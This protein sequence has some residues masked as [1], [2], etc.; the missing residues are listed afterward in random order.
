MTSMNAAPSEQP[1][2]A[3]L[4]LG[5]RPSIIIGA[6]GA[7]I[8]LACLAEWTPDAY[9]YLR[10]A[11]VAVAGLLVFFAGLALRHRPGEKQ[12]DVDRRRN[13]G[14]MIAAIVVGGFWAFTYGSF[15]RELNMLADLF[16]AVAYVTIGLLI[17]AP[18]PVGLNGRRT[19]LAV[20]AAICIAVVFV[21]W[22]SRSL[23]AGQ[24]EW[25][26][27]LEYAADEGEEDTVAFCR[28]INEEPDDSG[29]RFG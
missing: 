11:L 6:I 7:V 26:E 12:D 27:C 5:P 3:Q 14:A 1:E 20:I 2:R 15:D 21:L 17:S 16:T 22:S 25:Q 29:G 28:M 19:G 4:I 9:V 24:R 13:I 18:G 8:A 23:L 10:N